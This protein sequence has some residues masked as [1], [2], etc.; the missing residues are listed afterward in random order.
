MDKELVTNLDIIVYNLNCKRKSDS[1]G[2]PCV[3]KNVVE[4]YYFKG[5]CYRSVSPVTAK[6]CCDLF[7]C[8]KVLLEDDGVRDF[9]SEPMNKEFIVKYL[10][11]CH[12]SYTMDDRYEDF[13]LDKERHIYFID[14]HPILI[15]PNL[16]N[17]MSYRTNYEIMLRE[18]IDK[19]VMD[20]YDITKIVV[21]KSFR[22]T[23]EG[24]D[25]SRRFRLE[26]FKMCQD[27]KNS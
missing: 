20:R 3:L 24:L 4:S 8:R 14:S 11:D 5:N 16:L 18:A 25:E 22:E 21:P 27:V 17:V 2:N 13:C 9:L 12:G 7:G 1:F 23:F 26:L 10:D 19:A 15:G 6:E